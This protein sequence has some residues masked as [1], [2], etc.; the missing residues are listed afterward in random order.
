[1]KTST[2]FGLLA[3]AVFTGAM[4]VN[5]ASKTSQY[6]DFKSAKESGEEVHVVASWVKREQAVYDATRDIFSFYA[7][8]SLQTIALVHYPDPKPA[9][10]EAAEKIVLI[11]KY[12]Q[13]AFRADKILMKCPSKYEEKTIQ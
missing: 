8:D 9:N 11:G 3:L 6:T 13:D 7:Q 4:L 1:M 12:Q 5:F 10:F 2:L